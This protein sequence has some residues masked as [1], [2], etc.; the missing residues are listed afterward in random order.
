MAEEKNPITQEGPL[1]VEGSCLLEERRLEK[2]EKPKR[3]KNFGQRIAE[4][5]FPK[6]PKK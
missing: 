1:A 5:F 4:G 3:K 2:K 6:P